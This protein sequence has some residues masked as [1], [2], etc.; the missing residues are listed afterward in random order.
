MK[1]EYAIQYKSLTAGWFAIL[2]STVSRD[3]D[4]VKVMLQNIVGIYG[5]GKHRIVSRPWCML[6]KDRQKVKWEAVA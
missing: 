2:P 5:S 6:L 4:A 1:K 3:L